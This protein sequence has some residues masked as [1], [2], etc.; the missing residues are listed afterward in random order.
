MKH[1]RIS[2]CSQPCRSA[3]VLTTQILHASTH[4]R[5]STCVGSCIQTFSLTSR[6]YS[7]SSAALTFHHRLNSPPT[8]CIW[9][10]TQ[11]S[12]NPFL[13]VRGC[14]NFILEV[15]LQLLSVPFPTRYHQILHKKKI[16]KAISCLSKI[17]SRAKTT[18]WGKQ[19][20]NTM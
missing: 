12:V 10:R 19:I 3:P 8:L 5:P 2:A 7:L 13:E 6:K 17:I 9:D 16:D 20:T 11:A 1:F 15:Q 4:L 14:L 18:L